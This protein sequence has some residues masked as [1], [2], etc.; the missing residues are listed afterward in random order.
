MTKYKKL[1]SYKYEYKLKTFIKINNNYFLIGNCKCIKIILKC[2]KIS[3]L[4]NT[5]DS[6]WSNITQ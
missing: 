6:S 5:Y 4:R 2:N 1:Y 3:I